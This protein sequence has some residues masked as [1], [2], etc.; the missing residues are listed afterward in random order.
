MLDTQQIDRF[1]EKGY[2][3]V[4]GLFAP[5][6]LEPLRAEL[7][8]VI[9]ET[10]R[11]LAAEGVINNT[12]QHE[13]FERRLTRLLADSP[14]QA[15]R[16]FSAIEG[17]AGGGHR[18]RAMFDVL[19]HPRLLDLMECLLG[20]ELIASSVYRVRPKVPG[21]AKGVVPWHQDS[22]YFAAH[23]DT[24][25][26]VTCWIPLVDATPENGCLQ[27]LP[28]AHRAGVVRHYAGGPSGFLVIQDGDLPLPSKEAV[29]VPVA[30]G[31][32]LLMT[33]L[34]PHCSTPNTSDVIRWSIDLRYQGED[35]PTNAFEAPEEFRFDAPVDTWACY[36]PEGDFVVRSRRDPTR[37][38]TFEQFAERRARYERTS[39]PFPDRGWTRIGA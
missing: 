17:R 22:G 36:P 8:S 9:D 18:G 35:V 33:N 16:F 14:D 10:A 1:Y 30:L 23:C 13:P 2:L 6:D 25:L 7:A 12:H 29:A 5:G 20:P 39:L 28:C 21:L 32:V 4:S 11:R 26:I 38:H 27:V 24:K 19:T 31:G 15:Q 37:V 3:V 34:T